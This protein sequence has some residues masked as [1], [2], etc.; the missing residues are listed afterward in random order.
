MADSETSGKGT[1]LYFKFTELVIIIV[2]TD[3]RQYM[4]DYINVA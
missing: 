2:I 1:A 3:V 4:G